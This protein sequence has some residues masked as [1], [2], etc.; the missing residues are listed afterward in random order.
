MTDLLPILKKTIKDFIIDFVLLG[1]MIL[2]DMESNKSSD[3]KKKSEAYN[4]FKIMRNLLIRDDSEKD[5]FKTDL[6]PVYIMKKIYYEFYARLYNI[7]QQ[8]IGQ[9]QGCYNNMDASIVFPILFN[10]DYYKCL[11]NNAKSNLLGCNDLFSELLGPN[12]LNKIT[13]LITQIEAKNE[14]KFTVGTPLSETTMLDKFQKCTGGDRSNVENASGK[15]PTPPLGVLISSIKLKLNTIVNKLNN[16][17]TRNLFEKTESGEFEIEYDE[18]YKLLDLNSIQ[19]DTAEEK[20]ESPYIK[21]IIKS[22]NLTITDDEND[23]L[24]KFFKTK[25]ENDK[26]KYNQFLQK[27]LAA[28]SNNEIIS[29][30]KFM[31]KFSENIANEMIGDTNLVCENYLENTQEGFVGNLKENQLNRIMKA[32][33]FALLF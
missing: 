5:Y 3:I 26:N 27:Y 19:G 16:N 18:M 33:L 25:Y 1:M 14:E 17:S 32:I 20:N 2:K 15:L 11:P 21:L 22:I 28:K 24:E 29:I 12:K 7:F 8:H 4:Q 30:N 31:D 9:T 10:V 13:E 6:A 23:K